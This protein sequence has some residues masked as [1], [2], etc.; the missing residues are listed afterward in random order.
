[1]ISVTLL[2][3]WDL[4]VFV[5]DRRTYLIFSVGQVGIRDKLGD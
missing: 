4:A 2:V 1:V 3:A 5:L